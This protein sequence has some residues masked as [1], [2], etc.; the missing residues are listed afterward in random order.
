LLLHTG[1]SGTKAF[2]EWLGIAFILFG[3]L[4]ALAN[5]S[6]TIRYL[7]GLKG[8]IIATAVI[9]SLGFSSITSS[10]SQALPIK[11]VFSTVLHAPLKNVA[12]LY[13]KSPDA[14]ANQLRDKGYAIAGTDRS[15]EEIARANSTDPNTL[16]AVL[17]ARGEGGRH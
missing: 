9:A 5:W 3:V 10:E 16:L 6:L 2:H 17:F 8:G 4:H 1:G 13:D 7:L 15:L 11:A 14:L 12:A